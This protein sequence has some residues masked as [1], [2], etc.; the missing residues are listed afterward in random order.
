MSQVNGGKGIHVR[1]CTTGHLAAFPTVLAFPCRLRVRVTARTPVHAGA[2]S[3]DRS[4]LTRL[5]IGETWTAKQWEFAQRYS[6]GNPFHE[7]TTD[8]ASNYPFNAIQIFV[9]LEGFHF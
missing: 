2:S 5:S 9:E 3:G 4:H 1:E 7:F 8:L 6:A